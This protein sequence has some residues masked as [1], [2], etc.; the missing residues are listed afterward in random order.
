MSGFRRH[1]F[2]HQGKKILQMFSGYTNEQRQ[3]HNKSAKLLNEIV[4]NERRCSRILKE[5]KYNWQPSV[6]GLIGKSA[7]CYEARV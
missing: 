3:R 5:S 2:R 1:A 7:T 4:L 6:R